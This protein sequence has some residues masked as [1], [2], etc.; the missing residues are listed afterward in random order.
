MLGKDTDL[1]RRS[2]SVP[3]ESMGLESVIES[4]ILATHLH[5]LKSPRIVRRALE[6]SELFDRQ[7]LLHELDNISL[8]D[9]GVLGREVS[10]YVM[11]NLEVERGGDAETKGAQVLRVSFRHSHAE[12]GAGV[13]VELALPARCR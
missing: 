5:I 3:N 2:G 9:E 6:E 11:T 10:N 8:D 12:D 1:A 13:G 4:E 7:S